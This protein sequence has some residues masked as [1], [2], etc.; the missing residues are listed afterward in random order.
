MAIEQEESLVEI[1][2]IEFVE[3]AVKLPEISV[4]AALEVGLL[5]RIPLG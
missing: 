5:L 2:R 3:E 4:A 1:R